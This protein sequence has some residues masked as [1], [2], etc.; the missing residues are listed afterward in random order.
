[1]FTLLHT[2]IESSGGKSLIGM[3]EAKEYMK[4]N[5]KK[6]LVKVMQRVN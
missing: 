2:E 4:K 3:I 6:G 5:D 1:M